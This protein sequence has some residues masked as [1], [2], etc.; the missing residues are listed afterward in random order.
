MDKRVTLPLPAP[1]DP[2]LAVPVSV[3]VPE[4]VVASATD[5][6]S[7]VTLPECAPSLV[8]DNRVASVEVTEVDRVVTVVDS[9]PT[10]RA[11]PV[12][13]LATSLETAHPV[14]VEVDSDPSVP[15]VLVD[16]VDPRSATTVVRK[17]T[18]PESALR[19]LAELAT[20]VVRSDTSLP[21]APTPVVTMPPPPNRVDLISLPILQAR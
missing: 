4:V 12:V 2:L 19:R 7:P 9:L 13:V 17:D 8:M 6:A 3:V 10:S 1:L 20:T 5:A 15:V 16:S 21:P 14:V 11:T 18:S